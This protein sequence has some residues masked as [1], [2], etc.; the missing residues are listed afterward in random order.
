MLAEDEDIQ[1]D[2]R[3]GYVEVWCACGASQ[4]SGCFLSYFVKNIYAGWVWWHIPL[5]PAPGGKGKW[6]LMSSRPIWSPWLAPEQP[7]VHS[8]TLTQKQTKRIGELIFIVLW[9]LMIAIF[10]KKLEPP[11]RWAP[12]HASVQLFWLDNEVERLTHFWKCH[13]LTETQECINV[14]KVGQL[15]TSIHALIHCSLLFFFLFFFFLLWM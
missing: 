9:L 7:G 6:V 2:T 15:S 8:E 4:Y 12:E 5:I 13:S 10:K 11:V 14:E 1:N 3:R